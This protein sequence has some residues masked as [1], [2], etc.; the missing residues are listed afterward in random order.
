MN[1]YKINAES[2][3]I[4]PSSRIGIFNNIKHFLIRFYYRKLCTIYTLNY[5]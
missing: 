2:K 3:G 1:N 5:Y 4:S